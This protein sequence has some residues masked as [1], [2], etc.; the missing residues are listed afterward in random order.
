MTDHGLASAW[1]ANTA[2]VPEES[3]E[4][5]HLGRSGCMEC[6][7]LAGLYGTLV[8]ASCAAW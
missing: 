7:R 8:E 3:A 2:L 6:I 4:A 5:Q 1:L